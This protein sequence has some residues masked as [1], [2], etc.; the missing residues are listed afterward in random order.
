MKDGMYTI[1]FAGQAG[2]GIGMLVFEGGRIYGTDTGNAK[3]DGGYQLNKS[4][5]LADVQLKVQMPRNQ[6]SVLGIEQ[7][8]DWALDVTTSMNPN[9]DE[10]NITAQT[11]VG[12]PVFA[13]YRFMRS[14]PVE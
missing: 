3:Y 11:N 2:A 6:L 1:E 5:G 7:P 9:E 10:G 8:F 12:R 14:L 13:H 4:T